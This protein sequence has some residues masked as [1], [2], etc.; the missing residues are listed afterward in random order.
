MGTGL[1]GH[2]APRTRY[3]ATV[4]CSNP[5]PAMFACHH[6]DIFLGVCISTKPNDARND[7]L[8]GVTLAGLPTSTLNMD[9]QENEKQCLAHYGEH[10]LRVVFN[11]GPKRPVSVLRCQD[12]VIHRISGELLDFLAKI[13]Y[14]PRGFLIFIAIYR[15]EKIP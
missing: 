15:L 2:A 3:N 5:V 4:A 14:C 13:F 7:V 10:C 11:Y 8:S 9:G 1:G 6:A 12:L